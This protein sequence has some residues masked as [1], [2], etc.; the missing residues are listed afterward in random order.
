MHLVLFDLIKFSLEAS[1][2]KIS[3]RLHP[4]EISRGSG[5]L[6][7]VGGQ[8]S[9]YLPRFGGVQIGARKA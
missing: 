2:L 5:N 7:G 9:Q 8:I 6:Q 1:T 3:P 4:R